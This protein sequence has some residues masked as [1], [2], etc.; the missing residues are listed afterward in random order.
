[1][2]KASSPLRYP[3]GKSCLYDLTVSIMRQNRLEHGHYAE[4]YAGGCGLALALLY[5]GHVAELHLNDIDPS[6]YAFWHSVLHDTAAFIDLVQTS[7]LTVEEWMRQRDIHR[8]I[9]ASSQLELGYA[10]FYLNRTN[11]SGII[12]GAGVI[13]GLQQTGNYKMDCRFNRED[14]ARRITRVSRYRDRIHFSNLD[15]LDFL[16]N[17]SA[18]PASSLIFIDP[19]YYNKGAALY[20]S[21]Y[22]PRDH[23]ALSQA[24][25]SLN[26]PW[27]LTYDD[28]PEI[29]ALY[30][31]ARQFSFDINYSIQQK[32]VGTELMVFAKGMTVPA[33]VRNRQ[34]SRPQ[35]RH[36][37]RSRMKSDSISTLPVSLVQTGTN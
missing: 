22:E 27:I 33:E 20:T 30:R 19:P 13:G 29:R 8:G 9:I 3:G 35:Y 24:V 6:I 17:L 28:T 18:P 11:R 21:F 10:A 37:A 36:A 23:A 4:P 2:S 31:D 5:G 34:V 25:Q 15:A 12:S 26:L 7:P 16:K 1:M 32:R 14:L